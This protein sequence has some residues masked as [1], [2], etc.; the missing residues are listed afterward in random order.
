MLFFSLAPRLKQ[1]DSSRTNG[2]QYASGDGEAGLIALVFWLTAIF[3]SFGLLAPRNATV[4]GMLL[5]CALS[6]STSLVLILEM[7]RPLDGWLRISS[8]PLDY[9]LTQLGH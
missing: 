7:D 3:G 5:V 1:P 2:S 4:M 6:V 8:A 9:C